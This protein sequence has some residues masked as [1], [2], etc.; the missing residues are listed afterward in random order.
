V[1]TA[2]VSECCAVLPI[3]AGLNFAVTALAISASRCY[4]ALVSESGCS[5]SSSRCFAASSVAVEFSETDFVV[6]AGSA[7]CRGLLGREHARQ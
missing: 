1:T 4:A 7:A 3:I 6:T 5:V 2:V